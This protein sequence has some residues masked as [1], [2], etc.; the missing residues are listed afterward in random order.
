M[1][2]QQDHEATPSKK[3]YRGSWLLE[4]RAQLQWAGLAVLL[5]LLAW[6]L[7]P[8]L[9]A[10]NATGQCLSSFSKLSESEM[11]RR[12]VK[13]IVAH[14]LEGAREEEKPGRLKIMFLG[15]S[16]TQQELIQRN[17]SGTLLDLL[18]ERPLLLSDEKQLNQFYA[19]IDKGEFTILNYSPET[20]YSLLL[21]P[22]KSLYRAESTIVIDFFNRNKHLGLVDETLN[23][24]GN[25]LYQNE[26]YGLDTA[27]CGGKPNIDNEEITAAK[28]SN[29]D[30]INFSKKYPQHESHFLVSNCGVVWFPTPDDDRT[31]FLFD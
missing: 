15:R 5:L 25:Y 3:M 26:Y 13:S 12:V 30:V 6:A 17:Q 28:K 21:I 18:K 31:N 9:S 20:T 10:Y 14:Y 1:D 19:E 24:F 22:G 23:N 4:H 29:L 11:K 27:C 16:V 2:S 7:P 8:L